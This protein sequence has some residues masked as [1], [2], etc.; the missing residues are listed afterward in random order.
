VHRARL[1]LA[2]ARG[3]RLA[4]TVRLYAATA[5]DWRTAR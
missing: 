1:G 3:A 5:A 4:D 2:E